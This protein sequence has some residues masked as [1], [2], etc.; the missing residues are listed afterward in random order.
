VTPD[1]QPAP[2]G[3]ASTLRL[4]V[5][6]VLVAAALTTALLGFLRLIR[7][8]EAGGYGTSEMRTSLV[9]LGAAGAMLAAGIAVVIWEIAKRYE[10]R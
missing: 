1:R 4:I 2:S 9:V 7:V 8:L 6:A 5:G 3:D 10:R